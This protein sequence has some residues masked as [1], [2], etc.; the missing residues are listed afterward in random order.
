[1][2]D[3]RFNEILDSACERVKLKE[4]VW[5]IYP[6]RDLVVKATK[7]LEDLLASAA[8]KETRA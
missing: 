7:L 3:K 5:Q 8:K 4:L 2:S 6:D 1:M